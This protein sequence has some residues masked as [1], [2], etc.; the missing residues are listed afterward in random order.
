MSD[1]GIIL[2]KHVNVII[3]KYNFSIA[4]CNFSPQKRTIKV[5]NDYETKFHFLSFPHLTFL[6]CYEKFNRG[7]FRFIK[8]YVGC[9]DKPV[10]T[11]NDVLVSL[12]VGNYNSNY[13]RMCMGSFPYKN[14]SSLDEL[15]DVTISHFWQSS[16]TNIYHLNE[17]Q[18]NSKFWKTRL[19]TPPVSA[20]TLKSIIMVGE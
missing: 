6:V 13:L 5:A 14:F 20:H 18:K 9:S 8:L 16:F 10:T 17:W 1:E 2:P 11:V 12:P 4:I 19:N 7:S 15:I 3:D